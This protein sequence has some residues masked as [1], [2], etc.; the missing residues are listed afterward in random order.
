MTVSPFSAM[1]S[2][3]APVSTLIPG[4]IPLLAR[5]F[6]N[7]VPSALDCRIVSSNRITPEM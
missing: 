7:G 5:S 2:C 3:F 6:G 4:M 1:A